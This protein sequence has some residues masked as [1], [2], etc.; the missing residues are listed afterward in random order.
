MQYET[1]K[2]QVGIS[3]SKQP[4]IYVASTIGT[5]QFQQQSTQHSAT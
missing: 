2:Q 1:K 3:R 5:V 4:K